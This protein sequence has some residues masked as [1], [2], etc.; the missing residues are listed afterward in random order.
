LQTRTLFEKC[1]G[2]VFRVEEAERPEGLD[3]ALACLPLGRVLGAKAYM[4]AIWVEAENLEIV[5][6][7]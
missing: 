4:D 1:P 7:N 2:R 3:I 5:A 6:R